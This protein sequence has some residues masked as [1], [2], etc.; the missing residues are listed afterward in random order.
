MQISCCGSRVIQSILLSKINLLSL[1]YPFEKRE[2]N[3]I[4]D[5]IKKC[6]NQIESIDLRFMFSSG[7]NIMNRIS[8]ME[9]IQEYVLF[10]STINMR[11]YDLLNWKLARTVYVQKST[12]LILI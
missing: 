2:K 10:P 5:T 3:E 7:P 11:N 12:N 8:R 6:I 1:V 9:V 4:M